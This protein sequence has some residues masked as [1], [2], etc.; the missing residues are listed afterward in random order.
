MADRHES[1][2]SLLPR[3][4]AFARALLREPDLAAD[5]V[6][7]AVSRALSAR[8]VPRDLPAYRAW[9]FTI[10]RNVAIDEFRRRQRPEAAEDA[11][12]DL[13][14]FDDAR[15]A[16]ITV[17]QGLSMLSSQHREIIALIDIAGFGYGEAADMLQVPVGTVM[18]RITR[19]RAAL[20]AAIEQST[21]RP[22][23]SRHGH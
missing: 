15:I 20:L 5:A 13:W 11:S 9:M 14:R 23:K 2:V 1:L 21:V 12:A 7:E 3:L 19:A 16:K 10:V 17:A 6:Q 4:V 8:R 22:L 18:S